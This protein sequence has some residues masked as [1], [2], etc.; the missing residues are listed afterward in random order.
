MRFRDKSKLEIFIVGQQPTVLA[1]PIMTL[2]LEAYQIHE[3][4]TPTIVYDL[5]ILAGMSCL[6]GSSKMFSRD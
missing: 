3:Q 1:C 6:L 4:S 2:N 5:E